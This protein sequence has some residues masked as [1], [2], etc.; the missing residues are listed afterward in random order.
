MYAL[1]LFAGALLAA[2][3]PQ[4]AN[5]ADL[6]QAVKVAMESYA[7]DDM[8]SFEA[9]A[10]DVDWAL[11]NLRE[12]MD[13]HHAGLVHLV[14]GLSHWDPQQSEQAQPY[15][16]AARVIHADSRMV[17]EALAPLPEVFAQWESLQPVSPEQENL[18]PA[19]R[20]HLQL[21]GEPAEHYP[22]QQPY[23]LQRIKGKESV[24]ETVYVHPSDE[25]PSYPHLRPRL[26]AVL[27]PSALASGGLLFWAGS[28]DAQFDE[29]WQGFHDGT[30]SATGA[31][32]TKEMEDIKRRNNIAFTA[33]CGL[34]AVS[35][36]ATGIL[37]FSF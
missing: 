21:D 29:K 23:V 18:P 12:P 15:L 25:L 7:S 28:L 19:A 33:G 30:E 10:R 3:E 4:R 9:A 20:G 14:H 8:P 24:I 37:V 36:V 17:S 31:A 34:G 5:L 2:E 13:R 1:P 26:L 22:A 32:F 11:E 6:D 27:I 16:L 35:L